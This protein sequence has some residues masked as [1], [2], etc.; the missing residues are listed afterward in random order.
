MKERMAD[1]ALAL[2]NAGVGQEAIE[3]AERLLAANRTEDLIRHLRLL[4]CDLMD[5][6]HKTQRSVDCMDYLI[7][8]TEKAIA[9]R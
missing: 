2:S 9:T 1:M 3:T 5:D 7:R 6:L 4:R 8:K